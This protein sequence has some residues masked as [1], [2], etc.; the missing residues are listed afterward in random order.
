M[1]KPRIA[2]SAAMIVLGAFALTGCTGGGDTDPTPM[3]TETQATG[4]LTDIV[5]TPGSGENFAGALTDASTETCELADEA[6]TAAGTVTNSTDAAVNYRI[7]VSFLTTTGDTRALTQV[8][9][10][11]VEPGADGEWTTSAAITDEGLE[12]VL[13]VERYNVDGSA[14]EGEETGEGE[15][16]EEAPEGENPE[17]GDEEQPEG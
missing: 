14:P 8:N 10:D 5:D 2:A 3:P 4:G 1:I 12:C 6:W 7:Y 17:E 13:R 15:G 16:T 11:G 9:V